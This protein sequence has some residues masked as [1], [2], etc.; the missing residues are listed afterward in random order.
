MMMVM[1]NRTKRIFGLPLEDLAVT[2]AA[3]LT[4]SGSSDDMR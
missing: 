1:K 3:D 2:I 4:G